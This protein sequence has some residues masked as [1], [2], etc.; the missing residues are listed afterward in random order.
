M[1]ALITARSSDIPAGLT[2]AI[3]WIAQNLP[4]YLLPPVQRPPHGTVSRRAAD[5][6]VQLLVRY[7][8]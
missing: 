1:F 6:W 8:S 2:L 4:L 5:G 7:A 3:A